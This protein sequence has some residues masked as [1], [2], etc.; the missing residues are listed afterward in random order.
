M[1]L[2]AVLT[3]CLTA[4][5]KGDVQHVFFVPDVSSDLYSQEEIAAGVETVKEYFRQ[6]FSGC[7]LT[8]IQYAGDRKSLEWSGEQDAMVFISTFDV[9][10][11][12]GDGSL[13]PY[14]TYSNWQWILV[15]DEDGNWQ[16][17]DHGYG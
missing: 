15:R 1:G 14:S 3:L 8:S 16:H 11:S 6:E 13:T 5:G 12:G 4:C 17:K 7:A 9:G 10:A 2:A